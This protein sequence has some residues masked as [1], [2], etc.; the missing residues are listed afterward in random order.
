MEGSMMK[1]ALIIDGKVEQVQPNEEIGFVEVEDDVVCGMVIT[2]DGF[3][4]PPKTAD[5]LAEIAR[6]E[7]SKLHD[8]AMLQ[9]FI[10]G[11]NTDGTD[12]YIS[13]TKEDGDGMMQV[14]AAFSKIK[15]GIAL[16]LIPPETPIVT[17]IHFANKTKL[18]M[19]ENEFEVFA[20]QFSIER[21]KF[22]V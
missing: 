21:G 13:V 1:Y 20:I 19:S 3:I 6:Q 8:E 18:P 11:T 4:I 17:V 10:F 14:E 22:F 7:A 5:E 2:I 15:R 12:R 16:G 9:G